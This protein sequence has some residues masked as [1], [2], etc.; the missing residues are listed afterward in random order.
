MF[1][2]IKSYTHNRR[3][4]VV[5]DNNRRYSSVMVFR[6]VEFCHQLLIVFM[7]DLMKKLL[8]FIKRAMY[9]YDLV[10]RSTEEYAATAQIRLQ[11]AINV[12]LN[13]ANE[14]SVKITGKDRLSLTAVC[15]VPVV[16]VRLSVHVHFSLGLSPRDS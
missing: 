3:A 6:K 12:L 10:M 8:V 9:A 4:R 16:V 11:T 2:W 15:G 13:W 1:K 14:L 7:N 5:I